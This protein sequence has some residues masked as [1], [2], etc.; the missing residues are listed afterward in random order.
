MEDGEPRG[1]AIVGQVGIEVSELVGRAQGFVRDG[2]EGQG[3]HV[4]PDALGASRLLDATARP[5]RTPL[6]VL[7]VAAERA[8]KDQLLDG[9]SGGARGVTERALV[10]GDRAPAHR[11]EGF[12]GASLL[13]DRTAAAGIGGIQEQHGDTRSFVRGPEQ[14][15]RH[16]KQQP[17][18]VSGKRVG[19]DGA[20]VLDPA[21][22]LQSGI[23]DRARGPAPRI[24]H[25]A[26]PAGVLL[27]PARVVQGHLGP[28]RS[29]SEAWCRGDGHEKRRRRSERR[30]SLVMEVAARYR[31]VGPLSTIPFPRR[32]ARG[33]RSRPPG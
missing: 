32:S 10:D 28:F 31:G 22:G 15:A 1:E 3:G 16:R 20:S 4:K 24:G 11:L 2:S 18:P 8:C 23:D 21:Q 17:G 12:G 33:R 14:R 13:D 29:C 6:A 25:E 7:L 5:E 30:C 9:G 27:G 19:S 26:D